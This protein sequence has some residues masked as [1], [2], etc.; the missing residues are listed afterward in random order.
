MR[1]K[2]KNTNNEKDCHLLFSLIVLASCKKH[3]DGDNVFKGP[4]QQFQGGKAWTWLQTNKDGHPE[5]MAIAIDQAA[6]STLDPGNDESHSASDELSLKFHPKAAVTPFTHALLEWNPHGHEPAG[7]YDKP[8][9]DFHFYIQSESERLAIPPYMQDS[10]KFLLFPA[11]GYL[12]PNLRPFPGG[13]PEMGTHWVDVTTPEL[14][15]QPFTQT[16]LYGTYDGK[17]TFYEPMITSGFSG[18]EF[19]LRAGN[20]PAGK[21]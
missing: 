6:L 12:A 13:V 11:Q 21:I 3:N 18:R 14:N 17:V 4:D 10:S 7:I 5:M 19:R 15:G 16:F 1:N 20:S 9:F 8:H 2:I